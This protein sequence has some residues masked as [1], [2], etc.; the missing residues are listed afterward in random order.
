MVYVVRD[1]I[2]TFA[3]AYGA[4]RINDF[5]AFLRTTPIKQYAGPYAIHVVKW[6]LWAT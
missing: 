6:G 5:C 1:I 4:S 3:L 2:L